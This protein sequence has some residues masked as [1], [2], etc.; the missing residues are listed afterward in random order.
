MDCKMTA[1]VILFIR[2]GIACEVSAEIAAVAESSA[3]GTVA[4]GWLVRFRLSRS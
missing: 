1:S 2:I 4:S 3:P